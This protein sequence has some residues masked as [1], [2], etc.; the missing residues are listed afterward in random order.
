MKLLK[1]RFT[2]RFQSADSLMVQTK[3]VT[4]MPD[5]NTKMHFMRLGEIILFC[6][7]YSSSYQRSHGLTFV[8]KVTNGAEYNVGTLISRFVDDYFKNP[9]T[10]LFYKEVRFKSVSLTCL[11]SAFST[12]NLPL[13]GVADPR[14]FKLLAQF[15]DTMYDSRPAIVGNVTLRGLPTAMELWDS[16]INSQ[17]GV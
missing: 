6:V 16:T 10:P 17:Q 1:A 13:Q 14:P 7:T 2:V 15:V 11:S 5:L 4:S 3:H 8:F 9:V 12:G